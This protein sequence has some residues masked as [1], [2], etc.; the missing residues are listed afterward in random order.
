MAAW[1]HLPDA[2]LS[3]SMVTA[4]KIEPRRRMSI[5]APRELLHLGL[6]SQK[7]LA[8]SC[9]HL[10]TPRHF[11]KSSAA[12]VPS[13]AGKTG[14]LA[15][16]EQRSAC[17]TASGVPLLATKLALTAWVSGQMQWCVLIP[18]EQHLHSVSIFVSCRLSSKKRRHR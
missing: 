15:N 2:G 9:S 8:P 18:P 6:D 14:A 16:Q 17:H 5:P 13:V 3:A 7:H 1:A 12:C 11:F 4:G 10:S